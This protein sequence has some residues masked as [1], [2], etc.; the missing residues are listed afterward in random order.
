[1]MLVSCGR[2]S[3][4]GFLQYDNGQN[5]ENRILVFFS[6]ESLERLANAQTFFIFMDGT[7]SFTQLHT[8]RVPFK[9]VTG[10]AVYAFRKLIF[11]FL[12]SGRCRIAGTVGCC[13]LLRQS[14]I[15]IGGWDWR[16]WTLVSNC[17][18]VVFFTGQQG[19]CIPCPSQFRAKC[20][21]SFTF[22]IKGNS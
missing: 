12:H 19:L 11:C 5:A 18:L 2:N 10:T 7:F 20:M 1:M 4:G 14:D 21:V 6:Q 8:I 15:C 3:P 22:Y 9:D 17:A 16:S 13:V